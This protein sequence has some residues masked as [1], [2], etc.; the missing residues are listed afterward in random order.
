MSMVLDAQTG[1]LLGIILV[2]LALGGALVWRQQRQI[3]ELAGQHA[4]LAERTAALRD[5][6][7]LAEGEQERLEALLQ[8]TS[9]RIGNSLAT[10]SSLLGLQMLRSPSAEVKQALEAARSRVHAIASTHR[11]LRLGDDLQ[12]ASADEFLDAVLEDMARTTASSAVALVSEVDAIPI[13]ARDAT[14]LGILIGELVSNA[15]RH[16][17]PAGRVGRVLVRLQRDSGGMPVLSVVDDGVG[18]ER[19]LAAGEGG[20]GSVIVKQLAQQFGGVPHY[21]RSQ[22]GGLAVSIALP[23]LVR[24]PADG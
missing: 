11:R 2:V 4:R 9:H 17:F 1:W 6:Q 23:G 7:R 19:L 13:S 12:T 18:M 8:D 20:L 16:G 15:H 3:G 5:R 22:A 14:T 21:E 24:E 10:V